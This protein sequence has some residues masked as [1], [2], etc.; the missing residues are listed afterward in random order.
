M[1]QVIEKVTR[2]TPFNK[3]HDSGA[4]TSHCF[5]SSSTPASAAGPCP[6]QG[7]SLA[8]ATEKAAES[9]SSASKKVVSTQ[10]TRV[11]SHPT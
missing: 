8:G 9:R 5:T 1:I 7:S 4:S 2:L 6:E 3:N 11:S 10:M